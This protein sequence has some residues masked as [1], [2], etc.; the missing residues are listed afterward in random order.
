MTCPRTGH[1]MPLLCLPPPLHC[2]MFTGLCVSQC[3]PP[4]GPRASPG[5]HEVGVVSPLWSPRRGRAKKLAPHPPPFL[6]QARAASLSLLYLGA[7]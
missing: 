1:R 5:L 2:E 3:L 4:P 7:R 6:E